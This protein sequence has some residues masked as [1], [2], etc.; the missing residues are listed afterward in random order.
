MLTSE[1]AIKPGKPLLELTGLF[2]G[3]DQWLDL[4][5]AKFAHKDLFSYSSV[6]LIFNKVGALIFYEI[7]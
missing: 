3:S 1:K 4:T 2:S 7:G 6:F 5:I